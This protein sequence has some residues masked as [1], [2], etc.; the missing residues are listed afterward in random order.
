MYKRRSYYLTII[1]LLVAELVGSQTSNYKVSAE[2][3]PLV[4]LI[5]LLEKHYNT[6][7]SYPSNLLADQVFDLKTNTP[8]LSNILDELTSVYSLE[9][10]ILDDSTVLLRKRLTTK[11]SSYPNSKTISI[12]IKDSSD[13]TPLSDAAVGISGTSTGG[14]TDEHGKV[15]IT[16]VRSSDTIQVHLLGYKTLS[17]EIDDITNGE[18][19]LEAQSFEIEEVMIQD[20][21]DLINSHSDL[22]VYLDVRHIST[23]NSGLMG[24]DIMRQVQLLPGIAANND[25]S[26]RLNIR[27]GDDDGAL[28]IIDGIPLY[29]ASHYYGLFSSINPAYV[30]HTTLYKNNLPVSYDG[31]MDGMLEVSGLRLDTLDKTSGQLDIN[32]LTAAGAIRHSFDDNF[33]MSLGARSSLRNVSD[34][35]FLSL[36]NNSE[37]EAIQDGFDLTDR[38]I[39][40]S[41]IPEFSFYDFNGN[42]TYQWNNGSISLNYFRGTDDLDDS[43][44]NQFRTRRGR[45]TV[46][47]TERYL[48]TEDWHNEGASLKIDHRISSKL[49]LEHQLYHSIY[50]NLS[51]VGLSVTR[52]IPNI[53]RTFSVTNTR[54][55]FAEDLGL[56]T[57][58]TTRSKG[59]DWK[60]GIDVISHMTSSRIANKDE[61]LLRRSNDAIESSLFGSAMYKA[62][63]DLNIELGLRGTLFKDE[64]F[65]A[66]RINVS[67]NASDQVTLKSS[68]G[69]HNQYVR[70]LSFENAFGRTIDFWSLANNRNIRVGSTD[71]LMIGA[72][73]KIGRVNIDFETY[74]KERKNLLEQALFAPRFDDENIVPQQI[75]E[76]NYRLFSGDGKT[77]GLDFLLGYTYQKYSGW[78]SYTL[79]SSTINFDQILRGTT[80][81]TQ[82]DRRHQLNIVNEYRMGD[83]TLGTT[84]VY[85]SGRAYTDLNKISSF[86]RDQLR[87][88]DRISRLPT[89]IRA[90][91]GLSY[92]IN[93]NSSRVDIGL[94][95]YNLF[96]RSNVNYIQ[97]IFSIPTNTSQNPNRNINALLGT[98]SNLLNRTINLNLSYSF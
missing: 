41:T 22:G 33:S 14:Y 39:L 5:E 47:N 23:I 73:Y 54:E 77:I 74:Y 13:D 25:A 92:R 3:V 85:A 70:Q 9:Y 87:P 36:F 8:D 18:I 69:R 72:N 46:I 61:N 64:S 60:L 51:T 98:E 86:S 6:Q 44:E 1:F 7:F 24:A 31:K 12:I 97:Y 62:I 4:T 75:T 94:S 11:D 17:V 42:L 93:L 88:E 35:D 79:S 37:R 71:Q 91:L 59:V 40:I 27:G 76:E 16:S 67:Y 83:L 38:S 43:F 90:D 32:L 82:D 10:Q 96:N 15:S 57:I 2:S 89:Y 26:S 21:S 28:I 20:R 49:M 80:F 65:I 58:L 29:D 19:H 81:P 45:D 68:I 78:L 50:K 48:N 30:S 56:K 55:N 34:S 95:V 53:S 52:E 84:V 66:P 63:P